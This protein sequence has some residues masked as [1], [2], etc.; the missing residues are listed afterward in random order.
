MI[1]PHQSLTDS[2]L[3]RFLAVG[4]LIVAGSC[5]P[6]GE[7]IAQT[8]CDA[9]IADA[10]YTW[11]VNYYTDRTGG[12]NA[13][14]WEEF[15]STNL[16]TRNGTRPTG[17]VTGPDDNNIWYPKLPPRPTPDEMD[18]RRQPGESQDPPEM[19]TEVK[20]TLQCADGNL[21]ADRHLYRQTARAFRAGEKVAARY[22]LGRVLNASIPNGGTVENSEGR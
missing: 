7:P 15:S 12:A 3:I 17:A 6:S 13:N 21:K 10:T 5:T 11:R 4:V 19:L 14:R 2:K 1:S 22:T 8:I 20:Y 18:D 9:A 16:T